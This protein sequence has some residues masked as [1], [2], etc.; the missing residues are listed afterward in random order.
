MV[1]RNWRQWSSEDEYIRERARYKAKADIEK[2]KPKKR[3]WYQI[4]QI[5]SIIIMLIA[6]FY[7][8]G[9]FMGITFAKYFDPF[10]IGIIVFI[11]VI[12]IFAYK[13]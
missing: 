7:Y 12:F 3:N 5:S 6:L 11:T 9:S 13:Q 1:F 4:T 10:F 8:L 2:E